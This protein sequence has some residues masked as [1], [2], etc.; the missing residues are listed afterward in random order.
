MKALVVG[1]SGF[2]GSHVAD[3]LTQAG[4][5]VTILDIKRSNYLNDKQRIIIGDMLD[6]NVVEKAVWGHDLVYHFAGVT[7]IETGLDN[8]LNTAELNIIGTINLLKAASHFKVKRFLFA[9]SIYVY[10]DEGGFYRCSKQSAEAYIEEFQRM[11]GLPFTIMRYGTVYGPR[12]DDFNSV[13]A[14]LKQAMFERN[15]SVNGNGDEMREYIHVLD[16]AKSSVNILSKDYVNEHVVLTGNH[17]MKLIDLFK[18]IR[19]I[20]GLDV[21]IEMK[22]FDPT[23]S[24]RASQGHYSITPHRFKP[25]IAKK[26]V[27]NPYLDMGQGLLSCLEEVYQQ[28]SD[29]K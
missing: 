9:S 19:E 20:V 17:P 28:E 16:A 14:Y 24:S 23:E 8:P 25:K 5:E 15:I 18:M 21:N 26:L 4:H 1:G 27:N 10:S 29:K 3:E 7:Q 12:A 6:L 22:K 11:Y 13:K 2:I